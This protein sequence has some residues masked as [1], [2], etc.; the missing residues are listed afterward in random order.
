MYCDAVDWGRLERAAS[1]VSIPV[2]GNGG[3]RSHADLERLL[4]STGCRYAMVGRAA[5]GDPWVFSTRVA[6][7]PDAARFLLDYADVLRT[8]GGM[9]ARGSAGRVKQLLQHWTA[10][11][12]V[13]AERESWLREADPERLFARLADVA[14]AERDVRLNPPLEPTRALSE[15]ARVAV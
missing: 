5:L 14:G 15:S 6:R 13:G 12:L 3:L 7:A 10:G 4:A 1:A 9:S 11:D 8:E 2:C